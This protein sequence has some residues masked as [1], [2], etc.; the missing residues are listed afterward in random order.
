MSR[1]P[2]Q[3]DAAGASPARERPLAGRAAWLVTDGKAGHEAQAA[4]VADALGVVPDWRRVAASGLQKLLA[5]WG[6]PGRD[7]GCEPPWPAVAIGIGRTAMPALRLVRRMAGAGTFTVALQD[8]RTGPGIADL[9]WV[10]EHDRLRG[11]NVVTT[12]TPPNRFSARLL[13]ELRRDVPLQIAALPRPRVMLALGGNAKAW[14]W[15]DADADALGAAIT[16]LQRH[17]ASVMATASRRTPPTVATAVRLA[18]ADTPHIFWDGGGANP[19]ADFLAHADAIVV[20]ADSVS[21][22]GEACS[23][24]RPVYVFKPGGGSAKF[25]RFHEALVACG[26]TRPLLAGTRLDPDWTP[27][28]LRSAEAIAREIEARWTNRAQFLA[29]LMQSG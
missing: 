18:I 5:P 14:R 24:G 17:G 2:S 22:T 26:A 13:A 1:D 28:P 21:M 8:P 23:T 16:R 20:T 3:Q 19:Y 27:P 6:R 10:P 9:V 4:G 29:R 12:L 15:S 7:F 25:Q 11:A